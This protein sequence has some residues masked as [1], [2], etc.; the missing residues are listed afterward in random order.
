MSKRAKSCRQQS[1][2]LHGP[3][4]RPEAHLPAPA[5]P[6]RRG[7]PW[8]GRRFPVQFLRRRADECLFP[9]RVGIFA[10][11]IV[12]GDDHMIGKPVA[13]APISGRLPL[14]RS[15]PQ[16]NTTTSRLWRRAAASSARF[17][18]HRA[19]GHSRRKDAAAIRL[20]A[21]KF[22]T[23]PRALQLS[24]ACNARG[25]SPPAA[26]TSPAATSALDT[27]KSPTS[28]KSS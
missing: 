27:W 16:P 23:A 1:G 20:A 18:A 25:G 17:R 22:K 8:R 2:P 15:P 3:C 7:W 4:Q 13:G 9:D 5:S 19:C 28:G 24:S 21:D 11:R 26:M 12:V 6:R 10:A 14:S